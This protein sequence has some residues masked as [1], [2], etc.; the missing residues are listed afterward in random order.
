M[1]CE[2]TGQMGGGKY[3]R[4]SCYHCIKCSTANSLT[5][6]IRKWYLNSD[7]QPYSYSS[8][9]SGRCW[10]DKDQYQQSNLHVD[11]RNEGKGIV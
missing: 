11:G 2:S 8:G 4:E 1:L 9:I 10:R 3:L 5:V 7:I 6:L